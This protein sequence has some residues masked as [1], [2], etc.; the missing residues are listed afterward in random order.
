MQTASN[1]T[2]RRD[3]APGAGRLAAVIG[4][5]LIVGLTLG[6]ATRDRVTA[7]AAPGPAS[8]DEVL[9][10]AVGLVA[11]VLVV[12][13]LGSTVLAVLAGLPG[14]VGRAAGWADAQ[15]T[16]RALRHASGI[17]LGATIGTLGMPSAGLA[18]SGPLVVA[19]QSA[20]DPLTGWAPAFGSAPPGP[21]LGAPDPLFL[22]ARPSVRPQLAPDLFAGP[23]VG[24]PEGVVVHR[25]DT[26][27]DIVGRA[28][29]PAATDLEIAREWPRWY[30]HNRSVIGD[31]PDLILPGQVLTRPGS[32][33][34]SFSGAPD[35]IADEG[36]H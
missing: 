2:K 17:L 14:V 8:L 36:G 11:L 21:A 35:P 16:P 10:A 33:P 7:V 26:L 19:A 9:A 32:S 3:R 31:D 28:L 6:A 27:W 23:R 29:G 18:D 4:G 30:A 34:R 22:A 25:G 5:L 1:D 13:L 20:G 12:G 24:A 15:L